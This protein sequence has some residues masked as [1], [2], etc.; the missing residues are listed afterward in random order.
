MLQMPPPEYSNVYQK[1]LEEISQFRRELQVRLVARRFLV[2]MKMLILMMVMMRMFLMMMKMMLI[3][4][5]LMMMMMMMMR[6]MM[7]RVMMM[8]MR[9]NLL[10]FRLSMRP[11][12]RGLWS[13]S[14]RSCEK[15][16]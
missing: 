8:M 6:V 4:I 10:N 13:M 5:M 1:K 12:T 15:R 9:V 11:S 3:L 14:R 2:M 7:M 16:R